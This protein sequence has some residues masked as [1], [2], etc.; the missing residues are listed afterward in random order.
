MTISTLP[1]K[2]GPLLCLEI[3]AARADLRCAQVECEQLDSQLTSL[4][5]DIEAC[6]D[7]NFILP[8]PSS[9]SDH[10]LSRSRPQMPTPDLEQRPIGPSTYSPSNHAFVRSAPQ[11]T[12]SS[13]EQNEV[14]PTTHATPIPLP[15]SKHS[16]SSSEPQPPPP[17]PES[18]TR[19]TPSTT[20]LT[21]L[22]T[23]TGPILPQSSLT[24]DRFHRR[25]QWRAT[26]PPSRIW[27]EPWSSDDE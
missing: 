14:K 22:N 20:R 24:N 2:A 4:L 26:E 10:A 6:S 9:N 15:S 25:P 18:H 23:S 12:T 27:F 19:S 3:E 5:T 16:P 7:R 21:S 1:E 13:S 11:S 8:V 17:T